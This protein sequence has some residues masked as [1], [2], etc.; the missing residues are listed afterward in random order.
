[1]R[2]IQDC[3]ECPLCEGRTNVVYPDGDESSKVVLV[4]EAPGE[5]EDLTGKPFVGRAGK[6]LDN[7]LVEAGVDRKRILIT[8]TV[9]CRPP[10][11]R[12]P[13]KEE[14]SACRKYLESEL[15]N[16]S[17]VVCLGRSAIKDLI[18]IE[19]RMEDLVNTE[20]HLT[21]NGRDIIFIPAYHP[22]ACIYRKS[23]R[24]SLKETMDIVKKI[25]G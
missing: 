1:M 21:I 6:I 20:H 19:G 9:K 15:S 17:Y 12:D 10:N 18:G 7:A 8:N 24:S 23:A 4:G 3:R 14:M 5:N 16:C 13:T 22:M 11:N 25:I 2:P